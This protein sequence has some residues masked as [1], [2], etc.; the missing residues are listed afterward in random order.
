MLKVIILSLVATSIGCLFH[1][2][3]ELSHRNKIVALFSAVNESTWEHIKIGTSA[4]ILVFAAMLFFYPLASV[5]SAAAFALLIFIV[6]IPALFYPILAVMGR[7]SIPVSIVEFAFSIFISVLFFD[8]F[9]QQEY[10][11]PTVFISSVVL[12]VIMLSWGLFTFFPPKNFLFKDPR[13]NKYG[14]KAFE[15]GHKH[16]HN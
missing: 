9:V 16:H 7:H 4:L 1:F 5:I 15:K 10:S 13:N 3:Y 12:A 6:L 2:A 8:T 14:L 11:Q